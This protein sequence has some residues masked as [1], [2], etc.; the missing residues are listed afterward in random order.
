MSFATYK[1]DDHYPDLLKIW[2]SACFHCVAHGPAM[3]VATL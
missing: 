3:Y 2:V 1:Y